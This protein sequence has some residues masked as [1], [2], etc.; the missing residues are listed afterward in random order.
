MWFATNNQH[1]HAYRVYSRRLRVSVCAKHNA[2]VTSVS[3]DVVN[4]H[5]YK[6]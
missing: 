2:A 5:E 1:D 3:T 4:S 6:Q